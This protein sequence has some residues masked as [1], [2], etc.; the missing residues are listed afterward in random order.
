VFVAAEVCAA[1]VLLV[2]TGLL[3]RSLWTVEHIQPGFDPSHVTSAYLLKPKQDPGFKHRLE[4]ALS[5]APGAQA[6]ALV[7]PVPMSG[8]REGGLTSGFAIRGRAHQHG[9]PEWHGEGYFV[10]S[11]FFGTLRIPLLQG[12]GLADSDEESAPLVCVIDRKLADRFFPHQDPIGQEIGMYAGWAR[13]VGVVANIRGSTLESE[14]RPVVYYSIHQIPYFDQ[15]GVV[16]R[17]DAPGPPLIRNAVKRASGSAPVFDVR[18][19]DERIAESL[20]VRRILAQLITVFGA[21][22]LLLA[23]VGLAGVASQMVSERAKEIAVRVAI[24]ARPE[25]ILARYLGRGLTSAMI[26]LAAGVLAA[27]FLERRIANMLYGVEPLDLATFFAASLT[28]LIVLFP[29]VLWPAWRASK[30][31]PQ[32]VLRYE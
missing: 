13:I 30:I 6:A 21:I 7:Y 16:V 5:N 20:G 26:G 22:C 23:A 29:A 25:Q 11:G 8:G 18:T 3:L 32:T 9:E 1:L 4:E 28:V 10:S 14:S 12:R 15:A 2:S 27:A 19:M 17:S 31:D 24:G